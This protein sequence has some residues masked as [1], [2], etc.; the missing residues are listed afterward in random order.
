LGKT[1]RNV[2]LSDKSWVKQ[3]LF[4][5]KGDMP[6]ESLLVK[7]KENWYKWLFTLKISPKEILIW[8]DELT[9]KKLEEAKVYFNKYFK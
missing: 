1:I 6:L 7:I 9:L 5:G 3:D 8:K 2:F 4:I